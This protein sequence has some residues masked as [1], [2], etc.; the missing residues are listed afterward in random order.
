MTKD[1]SL[2]QEVVE[3]LGSVFSLEGE[4]ERK[5]EKR[6]ERRRERRRGAKQ[7]GSL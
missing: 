7:N 3:P 2:L 6:K 5:K 1:L 4:E